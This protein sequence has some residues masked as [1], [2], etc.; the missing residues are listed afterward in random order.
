MSLLAGRQKYLA[1]KK[2]DFLTTAQL[3]LY[4]AVMRFHTV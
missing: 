4:P 2:I 3:E 1:P